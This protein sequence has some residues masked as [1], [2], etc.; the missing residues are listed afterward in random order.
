[1]SDHEHGHG[2]HS[3]GVSG[4]ADAKRLSIALALIVGLMAV[5]VVVGILAAARDVEDRAG[6]ERG[7]GDV[8][9]VLLSQRFYWPLTNVTT[10]PATFGLPRT[11]L[12]STWS[13]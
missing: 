11:S 13:T 9:A 4:G 3:H 2:G 8:L 7:S 10:R 5:E 12:T 1:M 6:R